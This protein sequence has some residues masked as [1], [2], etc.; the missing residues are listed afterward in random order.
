MLPLRTAA[1][2]DQGE[3][4]RTFTPKIS[5]AQIFLKLWLQVENDKIISK[6]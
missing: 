2:R 3:Q 4:L 5:H 6:T 1:A